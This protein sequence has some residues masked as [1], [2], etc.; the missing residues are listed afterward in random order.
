MTHAIHGAPHS[1]L[2]HD[3]LYL[4]WDTLLVMLLAFLLLA[5]AIAL[6]A[7]KWGRKT[8]VVKNL[9]GLK[10]PGLAP[11]SP[12]HLP[13]PPPMVLNPDGSP[14]SPLLLSQQRT[15]SS[16]P[17]SVPASPVQQGMT[18][19][20]PMIDEEVSRALVGAS[21]AHMP[22]AKS[23]HD[24]PSRETS[25]SLSHPDAFSIENGNSMGFSVPPF[26]SLGSSSEGESPKERQA[27]IATA[28]GFGGGYGAEGDGDGDGDGRGSAKSPG[29]TGRSSST[30]QRESDVSPGRQRFAS[31]LG[32]EDMAA[33]KAEGEDELA[34]K[35]SS[36]AVT[37][38][39]DGD[40]ATGPSAG[41]V[42]GADGRAER[43]AAAPSP[44]TIRASMTESRRSASIDLGH[45]GRTSDLTQDG[46]ESKQSKASDDLAAP[47]SDPPLLTGPLSSMYTIHARY[48]KEFEEQEKL[49]KGGFGTVYRVRNKL[50][51]HGYAMKKVRLSSSHDDKLEKVLREVRILALLDHP[52]VVRYYQAWIEPITSDEAL[53]MQ[54]ERNEARQAGMSV[55]EMSEDSTTATT[56]FNLTS[57]NTYGTY[58][59]YGSSVPS[60]ELSTNGSPDGKRRS[61]PGAMRNARGGG[62]VGGTGT[63]PAPSFGEEDSS[64]LAGGA[65]SGDTGDFLS[66]GQLGIDLLQDTNVTHLNRRTSSTASTVIAG[67]G[68]PSPNSAMYGATSRDGSGGGGGDG[69]GSAETRSLLPGVLPSMGR[70]P[71]MGGGWNSNASA[72]SPTGSVSNLG[73]FTLD[74]GSGVGG[75]ENSVGSPSKEHSFG[76]L[77][78]DTSGNSLAWDELS[79]S[80]GGAS[81]RQRRK[82]WSRGSGK[83]GGSAN[84]SG[85]D[86]SKSTGSWSDEDGSESGD[87][88]PT[89]DRGTVATSR[90]RGGRHGGNGGRKGDMR[91]LRGRGGAGR[92]HSIHYFVWIS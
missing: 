70:S 34:R 23:M 61:P 38:T 36:N 92:V 27:R 31:A 13:S 26:M 17:G 77:A 69:S 85:S 25:A 74:G 86:S 82:F 50:D 84:G 66:H 83:D 10:S 67:G 33:L 57:R 49:G 20:P 3:G 41:G 28:G 62:R 48:R 60:E 45:G 91:A 22:K 88:S 44:A 68:A 11:E 81:Q 56:T 46:Q 76:S 37:H 9:L 65:Y 78:R 71:S 29:R 47:P 15:S 6:A 53:Q 24:I 14:P 43:R 4:T 64:L 5:G 19:P 63:R 7:F 52:H 35:E 87:E 39:D 18:A 79:A 75:E 30:D 12:G 16:G 1:G 90:S 89:E 42:D 40:N 55:T 58:G 59:T 51:G 80:G 32:P 72:F 8:A 73:G 54:Q 2:T 21:S